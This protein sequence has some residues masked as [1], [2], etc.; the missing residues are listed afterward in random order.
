MKQNNIPKQI[1][2]VV[3]KIKKDK[4]VIA[5][6]LFGSYL[7]K[8]EYSRDVDLCV[9]L[10][11]K[12]YEAKELG[13]K[14]LDYLTSAPDYFDIQIKFAEAVA[15]KTGIPLNKVLFTHTNF[16]RRFGLGSVSTTDESNLLWQDYI[17]RLSNPDNE[18]SI[19]DYTY[20]F[21]LNSPVEKPRPKLTFGCFSC[22]PIDKTG[23]VYLH[24]SNT[25]TDGQSPL[26]ADKLAI[27][28]KELRDMFVHIKREYHDAKIV[29]SG[30][31][32]HSLEVYRSL[33]PPAYNDSR[34]PMPPPPRIKGILIGDSFYD[35]TARCERILRQGF[36]SS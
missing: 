18:N 14:R 32:L 16:Y 26:A 34:T 22:D 33:F 13:K 23:V 19:E 36:L 35:M 17:R 2:E 5:I 20:D 15:E 9:V 31:W 8:K 12:N 11:K 27:R 28:K 6:F 10:D 21:Y 29:R 4:D 1:R 3:D 24:F 30:S 25:D 7:R